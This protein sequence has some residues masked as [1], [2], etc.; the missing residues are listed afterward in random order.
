MGLGTRLHGL[1]EMRLPSRP[2]LNTFAFLLARERTGI[3]SARSSGKNSASRQS[4][5]APMLNTDFPFFFPFF[6]VLCV[7]EGFGPPY[8]WVD[9]SP[10]LDVNV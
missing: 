4:C 5:F 10:N 1:L 2:L 9:D 6:W 8:E 3:F 7:A